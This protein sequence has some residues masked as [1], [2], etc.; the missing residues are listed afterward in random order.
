MRVRSS[1]AQQY[2]GVLR[3]TGLILVVGGLL[4]LSPLLALVAWPQE[5]RHA[6]A[7]LVPATVL[8]LGGGALWCVFR[9]A[10]ARD[11]SIQYGGVVILL[12]WLTVCLF[13]AWPLAV[14]Q[15]MSFT[16]AFFESV[17]GW[18]TTGL[19]VVDVTQSTHVILL[20]RSIMQLAG[21]AGF[22]IIMLAALVGPVG[23]ALTL[24]EGRTD[25]LVPHV[26]QSAKLVLLLYTGYAAAGV[27]AYI[28][29]GVNAFDAINH[30]FA[31]ISTGGFSTQPDSI[32]HW[33]SPAVEAVSI[34]L[35]VLGN[36]NFLT[37]FLL[38][39]GRFRAVARNGE[40]RL[41]AVLLPVCVLAL[42][43]LVC[44]PLYATLSKS[45]R[46]AVFETFTAL[47]TTG[48]STVS[49]DRWTS[50]GILILIVLM[51]IGGGTGSTAGGIKQYR[52]YV[53]FKTIVWDIRRAL[54]PRTAVV[55]NHIWQGE[56]KAF[57]TE[58]QLRKVGTFVF[59][60]LATYVVG[61]A[62]VAAHGFG[63]KESLFEFGSALGT[64]G[65]SVGVT[66]A[67]APALVLWTE[68]VGM[69]L[70]RLEFFVVIVSVVKIVRDARATIERC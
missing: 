68:I 61:A 62:I 3:Y 20:W 10:R 21:G 53:L 18:T 69:F 54:L 9:A 16:H 63:L 30:T 45:L 38:F 34:P 7:F 51:L 57:V 14:V 66:S 29:A 47:T 50:E 13:S 27:I 70:G 64:V 1:L 41:I 12:S 24:A 5:S 65:L 15:K 31:A 25:Q 58:A 43:F 22:A 8:C 6:A 42:L 59:L 44:L 2:A 37:A 26:R 48:F 56:S 33:D 4:M 32:G 35:M 67:Q 52:V 55:E 49:Y 28:L 23:P 11:L 39:R 40:V 19:S 60:Y 17:S 46:V 36:M